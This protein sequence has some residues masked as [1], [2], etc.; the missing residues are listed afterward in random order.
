[1]I[2]FGPYRL[3]PARRAVWRGDALLPVPPKAAEILAALARRAGELVTKQELMAQ[4]WPG[5][6]VEEANLSVNISIL[7]RA[8]GRQ[9][10]AQPY[11]QT[12]HR[13][14]YRFLGRPRAVRTTGPPVLA[15]LP[16]ATLGV[17][18][19]PA[20]GAG[21]ADALI[22]RLA[23]TGRVVVRPTSAVLRYA[24]PRDPL[25]AGREL[26]A[27]AVLDGAVLRHAGRLR[28]SVQLVPA[29]P[30]LRPWAEAFDVPYDDL[31]SVQQTLSE[32]VATALSLELSAA[33]RDR[34]RARPTR[35]LAA[36]EDYAR[37]RHLWG[38]FTPAS[39][40]RALD[41]FQ[42]AAARD[43]GYA[44]PHA[45]LA[46]LH[47]VSGFSGLVAPREA[48]RR[49]GEAAARALAC[50]PNL[51][52]A[53][54]AMAYRG[55]FEDWDFAGAAGRLLRAREAEPLSA[56]THQ[57]TSLL[58]AMLGRLDDGEAA[59]REA[60]ALDPA[61]VVVECL[62]AFL[63]L[64]RGDRRRELLAAR[65]AAELEPNR[66]LGYW[67]LGLA[68]LHAHRRAEAVASHR[69]AVEL[70]DGAPLLRAVLARTLALAG[71]RREARRL[72]SELSGLPHASRYQLA[73]VQ[74]ALGA[75]AAALESLTQAV[76][77][78]EG[79]VAWLA[80]DPMLAGVRRRRRFQQLLERVFAAAT[81]GPSP[82]GRRSAAAPPRARKGPREPGAAPR[83]RRAS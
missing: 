15:V 51:P 58:H 19:E 59:L 70:A 10:D 67:S 5:T 23:G 40:A 47:L 31:F 7:R 71:R 1:M 72:L 43:P 53:H 68:Q 8:L 44:A 83:S 48:W 42:A 3:D 18:D 49:A 22:T 75:P 30:G 16:F 52:A 80:V 2:E 9:E 61:S 24:G 33:E 81:P 27:D 21:M 62:E 66:F 6:F 57:W 29:E 78:R 74:L 50:D 77:A 14:G 32:R 63:A 12:I 79:W 64:L 45:G 65:R 34:L 4:V 55:L 73:T 25:Q 69:R 37:G 35:D 38:Q 36:Y 13:R 82:A 20:L 56:T 17:G 41:A 60:R 28:L 54:V 11:I 46:D 39:L 26:T 76:E